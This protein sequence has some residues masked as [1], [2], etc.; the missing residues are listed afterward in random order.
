M[1]P[2][3]PALQ[4][5]RLL[6]MLGNLLLLASSYLLLYIGGMYADVIYHREAARGDSD[7]A[8]VERPQLPATAPVPTM[9]PTTPPDELGEDMMRWGTV[10][11]VPHRA[12]PAPSST[13]A[14]HISTVERLVIPSVAID[15]KVIE[16]GWSTVEQGGEQVAVWDVAD[17]AVGHHKGSANPGEGSNIVLAGHVAGY[18]HVFRDLYYVR[19]GEPVTIYSAGQQHQYVIKERLIVEETNAS[20]E[21]LQ[22][23][24]QLIGPT[25]AEQVTMITCWPPTGP[26]KFTQRVVVHAVPVD[27][28][29]APQALRK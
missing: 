25:D 11:G 13:P 23:N 14:P 10:A 20:D 15:Y 6:N 8:L 9:R 7:I 24:A 29:D 3:T 26:K 28:P 4:R 18:G 1:P 16:V 5:Q 21:E 19:P 22:I 17:Y 2:L 12:T 27:A